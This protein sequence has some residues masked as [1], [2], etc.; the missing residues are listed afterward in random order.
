MSLVND[1]GWSTTDVLRI[2]KVIS[3]KWKVIVP[4]KD[5]SPKGKWSY[6]EL[7]DFLY[8]ESGNSLSWK[9]CTSK[10]MTAKNKFE[11]KWS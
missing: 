9:G 5:F 10:L 4:P 2:Q 3:K 8:F 6:E 1:Y 7:G 11:N